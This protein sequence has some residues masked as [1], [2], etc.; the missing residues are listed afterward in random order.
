M[1]YLKIALISSL[2]GSTVSCKQTTQA[3]A[4]PEVKEKAK[5]TTITGKS[6]IKK[7]WLYLVRPDAWNIKADIVDSCKTDENGKFAFSPSV[8]GMDEYL[9]SGRGF[10]LSTVFVENGDEMD[11]TVVG[12]GQGKKEVSF[13]GDNSEANNFWHKLWPLVGGF[14]R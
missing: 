11:I 5:T 7:K 13:G 10:V 3:T 1:I 2:L 8:E 6:E 12:N 9:I 4:T 14:P